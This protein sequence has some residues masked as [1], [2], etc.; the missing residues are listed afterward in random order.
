VSTD[1]TT[2][3][4]TPP[5]QVP[6]VGRTAELALLH[7]RLQKARHG[8]PQVILLSGD[9]GMG[10]SRLAREAAA[11]AE[12]LDMQVCVG[13]FIE[14][15]TAPYL[16]WTRALLPQLE[17]AGLL[18]P[19]AL[20][21]QTTVLDRLLGRVGTDENFSESSEGVLL[22]ALTDAVLLLAEHRPLLFVVDDL[23]WAEANALQAFL[24]LV[25]ALTDA[26]HHRR[27]PVCVLGL[28]RPPA[29]ATETE[30]LA[31]RCRRE[32]IVTWLELAGL[33]EVDT[34]ELLRQAMASP[35][36]QRLVALLQEAT[37]GNPLFIAEA[38]AYLSANSGL[39]RHGGY[40]LAT[41]DL[42][43][44]PPPAEITSA[45]AAR[46]EELSAECAH[47]LSIA[48]LVGDEF[49]TATLEAL[50]D[51]EADVVSALVDEAFEGRFL[52]DAGDG[53]R[54][55]HP[56]IRRVFALRG[57]ALRRRKTHL[58]IA[59]RLERLGAEA[60]GTTLA[61]AA[62]YLASGSAADP[63]VVGSWSI[64]AGTEALSMYAWGE[65][66]RYFDA[67]LGISAFR[68][69]LS[70]QECATALYRAG[71]GHLR[72]L[73][74]A[75]AR[76][77][78][79]EAVDGF[80]SIGDLE[81]WGLALADWLRAVYSHG[82]V[83]IGRPPDSAPF[84]AFIEAAGDSH[85]RSLGRVLEAWAEL[86]YIA[87][88]PR[89]EQCAA[90]A[91]AAA[92][93]DG[94]HELGALAS[95]ALGLAA[96]SALRFQDALEHYE[97]ATA[98][99]VQV[100]DPWYRSWS[101]QNAP[102]L[103]LCQGRIDEAQALTT[104]V[105]TA[106]IASRN[107][108]VFAQEAITR[109][110]ISSTRGDFEAADRYAGEA[111]GYLNLSD[112]SIAP[113][114]LYFTVAHNRLLRGDWEGAR[115]VVELLQQSGG[116]RA[117]WIVRQL[118]AASSGAAATAAEEIAATPAWAFWQ[119][120]VDIFVL[121]LISVRLE[122]A[123]ALSYPPLAQFPLEALQHAVDQGIVI[124]PS[125]CHLLRRQLGV[126]EFLAGN[127][128]AAEAD[129]EQAISAGRTIDARP[130]LARAHYDLA[131]VLLSRTDGPDRTRAANELRTA[132]ALF[133]EMAMAPFCDRAQK[134]AETHGIALPLRPTTTEPQSAIDL[135]VLLGI[136]AEESDVAV[137]DRLLLSPAT[138]ERHRLAI[139]ATI[140][141]A[142]AADAAAYLETSGLAFDSERSAR[143]HILEKPDG[144]GGLYVLMFSDIVDSTPLNAALGDVRYYELLRM[145]DDLIKRAVLQ[146]GGRVI[147]H[148][149]DGIFAAFR[150]AEKAVRVAIDLRDRFPIT[151]PDHEDRPLQIRLGLHAGEP[152]TT[153]TDLFGIAV[154]M[155]KRICDRAGDGC[156]LV[157]EPVRQLAAGSGF[158][159]SARGRYALKG[160][161]QRYQL[162]DVDRPDQVPK[163]S[164]N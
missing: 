110:Q 57:T 44:L 20:G 139:A 63:A 77:R 132:A 76:D 65:A 11:I 66:A 151:L 160:L 24:H 62:H 80:R 92:L 56:V 30:R 108:S 38:L 93:A 89:A 47:L 123:D 119:A 70:T 87:R 28:M 8:E 162:Y 48:A 51:G 161:A 34:N 59:Q 9:A 147:K 67:A 42:A 40:V 146:H 17:R 12:S 37:G 7:S 53:V 3:A 158:R 127:F 107:W 64:R 46:A 26:S 43:E 31:A 58:W 138:V 131:R 124:D 145:H 16:P 137:A 61:V 113:L 100:E 152:V 122:L 88:D 133:E 78:L 115:D 106:A 99:A 90:Q 154:T 55:A 10:K 95:S 35:C 5:S 142:D 125:S 69:S 117:A 149:G 164:T 96:G 32:P 36:E 45:I 103:L 112:Y 81:A 159:F 4:I 144:R 135:E 79:S 116:S 97:A 75:R 2:I 13:R 143:V 141:V 6:F 84:E 15:G 148:T 54:F 118:V 163:H 109:T 150:S 140:G 129:L 120:P 27:P 68:K 155:T 153:D 39:V 74:V 19:A 102:H 91:L 111:Q 41:L 156:V 121:P 82:A 21:R 1:P 50:T 49:T 60:G 130:E 85:P 52:V 72:S 136:A 23:Q 94:D 105:V 104:E 83:A 14:N 128:E 157:S 29:A 73:D 101:R 114:P 22:G 126:A 134:L 86:L 25:L 71:F 98:H 33:G 18:T